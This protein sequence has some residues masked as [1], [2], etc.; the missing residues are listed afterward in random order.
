M[1]ISFD[2]RGTA[3]AADAVC[4]GVRLIRHA[5]SLG[6]VESTMERRAAVPGQEHLPPTLLRLSVGIESVDDLWRDLDAA[7]QQ[8]QAVAR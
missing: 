7:L 1:V 2:V 5:T 4:A 6:A 8:S 3:A